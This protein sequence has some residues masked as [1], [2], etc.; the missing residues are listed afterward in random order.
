MGMHS[1]AVSYKNNKEKSLDK[2]MNCSQALMA[3]TCSPNY[4]GC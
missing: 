4:L 3:H 2:E 1:N